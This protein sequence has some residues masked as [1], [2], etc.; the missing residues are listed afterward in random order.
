ML[1]SCIP[2]LTSLIILVAHSAILAQ[3]GG[4]YDF[5]RLD[6]SP[7]SA[8][9]GG[10]WLTMTD[11]PNAIFYNPAGLASLS[12][13][14]F[15]AGFIKHLL[16]INS[17]YVSYGTSIPDFGFVGGGV[18]YINYGE[19][20][21]TGLEGQDLGTFGAGELALSLGYATDFESAL[22]YGAN[23]KYIYSS[24][25]EVSSNALAV[26]LGFQYI[27]V[28]NRLLLGASLMNLGT[29]LDPYTTVSEN[30]PLDFNA[31]MSVYP[32][33]LPAIITLTFH[34]LNE[35]Q[36]NFVDRLKNFSL[37]AELTPATGFDIRVGFNNQERQDLQIGSSGFAGFSAG[38]GFSAAG[39]T[40]DYSFNSMGDIGALH[41]VSVTF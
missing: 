35:Q 17:G 6:V 28:P 7:R 38:A 18:Q 32:E 10:G 19:F 36:D 34:R 23:L 40:V 8:A 37:G 39:Y 24:I 4:T 15:S 21:R 11:D 25:A 33:H 9:I 27:A 20:K 13:S 29:Q 2:Y 26:D 12:S 22:H 16:D 30:L 5:L 41:R 1:K 14:R 31:G 3:P